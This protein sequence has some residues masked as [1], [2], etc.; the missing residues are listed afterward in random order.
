MFH[1]SSIFF[2]ITANFAH[3]KN[4]TATVILLKHVIYKLER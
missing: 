2:V 1:L 4:D 3:S